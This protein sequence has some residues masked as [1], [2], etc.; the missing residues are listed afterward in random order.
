MLTTPRDVIAGL[1]SILLDCS[2]GC[3]RPKAQPVTIL[4]MDPGT[5]WLQRQNVI[6]KTRLPRR[7]HSEEP[8]IVSLD[9]LKSLLKEF[10][11]HPVRLQPDRFNGVA[12]W[13]DACS[14]LV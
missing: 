13:G 1:G 11:N 7:N 12:D 6:K 14:A 10:R 8:L 5:R 4:F 3:H 9:D 2:L